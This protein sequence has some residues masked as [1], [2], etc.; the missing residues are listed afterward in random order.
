MRALVLERKNELAIREIDLPLR[1]WARGCEDRHSHG[2]RLRQRRPLLHPWPHRPLC[3]ARADGARPR[4]LRHHHRGRAQACKA[5]VSAT[6]SAWSRAS[7]TPTRGASKLGQYNVDP[8][9]TFWATPP[10]HGMPDAVRR[11]SRGL[12]L[13]AARQR[14][15]RRGRHGRALRRRHAGRDKARITPG[16]SAWSSAPARS[17]SWWRSRRS[18]AAAAESIISDVQPQK[19]EDRRTA[20]RRSFRSNLAARS[21]CRCHR[22]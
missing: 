14:V 18:P 15:L 19:L 22:A 3:R 21:S 6:A 5:S 17:A 4:G 1:A 16:E 7:P 2:R 11:P 10:V 12:H 9:V 20:I 8:A 13:Q